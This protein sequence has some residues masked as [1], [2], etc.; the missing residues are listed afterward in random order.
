MSD[1]EEIDF[2]LVTNTQMLAPPPPL[3]KKTVIVSEW[4]T[5]SE[6]AAGFLCWE[7]TANDFSDYQD[8]GWEYKNGART[9]FVDKDS[10]IRFLSYTL[11]DQHG[12]R[13]W[14]TVADAKAVLGRLGRSTLVE[15]ITVSNRVNTAQEAAS[16]GNSDEI[17]SGS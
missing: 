7:M 17:Q 10:D 3:R 14:N 4:K 5:T 12:N 13:L 9:R 11:R 1:A 2:E 6:K 16:E 8:S 15:L